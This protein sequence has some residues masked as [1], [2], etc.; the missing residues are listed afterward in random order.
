MTW[1]KPRGHFGDYYFAI[2]DEN[3]LQILDINGKAMPNVRVE[4]FQRGTEVDPAGKAETE[5]GVTWYPVIEDDNFGKPCSKLP[6]IAG[7]TDAN[8]VIR[9][10][11][12]PAFEVKTLNG[13]HRKAN[14]W[15]N[16]D[17]VG[18]RGLMLVKV[19]KDNKVAYFYLE[20]IDYALGWYTGHK[21]KFTVNLQTPFGSA[22]SPN[23][24]G[25]VQWVYTDSTKK[26][27]KVTWSPAGAR[28]RHY[29]QMPIAYRVYR[30]IGDMGLNDKPWYAVA[31]LNPNPNVNQNSFEAIIDLDKTN[32]HDIVWFTSTQRFGVTT[33]AE[34]GIQ[35]EL[36]QAADANP[37]EPK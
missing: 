9:L 19:T 33:V 18:G 36:A 7:N 34:L 4:C 17:V 1:N 25:N 14:P 31:T 37:K 32:V 28:E 35:S 16:I 2:P 11:N 20:A 27:V 3:F 24:P 12:R 10:P 15:G 30:R 5:Q 29:Q 21:D 13:Y 6:V 22:D 26:Q 23:P 8:G